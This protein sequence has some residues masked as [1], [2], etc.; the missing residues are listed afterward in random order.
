MDERVEEIC[1]TAAAISLTIMMV[2]ATIR[3]VFGR[4]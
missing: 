4:Y 1:L 3:V 2:A